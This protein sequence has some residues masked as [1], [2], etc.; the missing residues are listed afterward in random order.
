MYINGGAPMFQSLRSRLITTY[1]LSF[2]IIILSLSSALYFRQRTNL[3]G[4][5]QD[6]S[7]NL[8]EQYAV[9]IST[10]LSAHIAQLESIAHSPETKAL[11]E[12]YIFNRYKEI[13]QTEDLLFFTGGLLTPDGIMLD[14]KGAR[15][16]VSDRQYFEDV[17]TKDMSYVIS[18]AIVGKFR[19]IPVFVIAVPIIDNDTVVGALVTPL[20]LN[21]VSAAISTVKITE[22][23]FGWIIDD[24]G[25]LIAHPTPGYIM[26][27]NIHQGDKNGFVG[28]TAVASQMATQ[29]SG[30]GHYYDE[31]SNTNKVLSYVTIPN[32]PNWRL[33]ISIPTEEIFVPLNELVTTIILSVLLALVL[34]LILATVFSITITKPILSLTAAVDHM[35]TGNLDIIPLSTSGREINTLITA[36][37]TMSS[38]LTMLSDNIEFQIGQRTQNLN[39]INKHL[40]EMA[41]RDHLTNLYNRNFL[42]NYLSSL[43]ESVDNNTLTNFSIIF[44]DLNN[45]KFYNDTYG[46]DIG[47]LILVECSKQLKSQF[48]DNDVVSRYGG[49]EFVIVVENIESRSLDALILKLKQLPF[50]STLYKDAI[51]SIISHDI[52]LDSKILSFA[53]G[54]SSY[55]RDSKMDINQL[56][57]SADQN[58]YRH[59]AKVKG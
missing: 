47:D 9:V 42:M 50:T 27:L 32:T 43:K 37:N 24:S 48:R 15:N 20:R 34:A 45:F 41:S 7:I 5:I 14:L 16:D 25:K 58:M 29:S 35:R 40:Q 51:A 39:D 23:T 54:F 1:I 38:D 53:I 31:N 26:N 10:T 2:C 28:L 12:D 18:D 36:F 52:R 46:H 22:N 33:G 11:N 30:T 59:K 8:A 49:D 57:Q 17:F 6:N 3:T 19:N 44:V 21:E 56:I 55:N 13:I 4:I